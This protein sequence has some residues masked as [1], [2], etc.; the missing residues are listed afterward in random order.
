RHTRFSRDWSSD[1]CSSDLLRAALRPRPA[2]PR[3]PHLRD[4]GPPGHL[5][6]RCL[7][8]TLLCALVALPATLAAQSPPRTASGHLSIRAVA[9]SEERRVGKECRSPSET[10]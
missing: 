4:R 1:V 7:A 6:L 3:D 10:A 5:G 8:F 2:A 9:R